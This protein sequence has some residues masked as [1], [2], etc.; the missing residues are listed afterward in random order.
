MKD[1][2]AKRLADNR[3]TVTAL[4]TGGK[5]AAEI[6]REF[7]CSRSYVSQML[8]EWR[9]DTGR[10]S[11]SAEAKAEIVR[12]AGEGVNS[13]QAAI[14]VGVSQSYAAKIMK[15]NGVFVNHKRRNGDPLEWH[16]DEII[17]L[18]VEEGWGVD[19]IGT[20]YG[21]NGGT[22]LQ[23]LRRRGVQIRPLRHYAHPVDES[24]F[25]SI[26][27]PEKAY[28]LGLWMAD[29]SVSTKPNISL[30]MTDG[31]A[32]RKAAACLKYGGPIKV[33]PPRGKMK[34]E[35]YQIR[36]GSRRLVDALTRLGCVPRKSWSAK[37]PAGDLVDPSLHPHLVRGWF[38]GDG[39]M[40]R[41]SAKTGR[42]Y[43]TW[44]V[45]G[46]KDA[47]EGIHA[48]VLAATGVSCYLTASNPNSES[49]H[50]TY[51]CVTMSDE[52]IKNICDWMYRGSTV[53]MDRKHDRYREF[54]AGYQ[55]A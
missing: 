40:Y 24:F 53:H 2:K 52:K 46:T 48:A 20:K 54:L 14:R 18:Y 15:E 47:C 4:F 27:T 50:V 49:G 10:R 6:G 5:T 55:G 8:R 41:H 28:V 37:F 43:W 1:N 31:D 30:A 17:R 16:R 21:A 32:V 3:Q 39:A 45:C 44:F 29:G 23:F 12:L 11:V 9:V 38:D 36:I 26:D 7:G 34:H 33:L 22:V 35:Q 13:R 19:R 51:K 42:S 25:D